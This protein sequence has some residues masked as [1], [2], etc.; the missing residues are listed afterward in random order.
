MSRQRYHI[1]LNLNHSDG[2]MDCMLREDWDRMQQAIQDERRAQYRKEHPEAD[3]ALMHFGE[4]ICGITLCELDIEAYDLEQARR[5]ALF[6]VGEYHN[7]NHAIFIESRSVVEGSKNETGEK[8]L[9]PIQVV[10]G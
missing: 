8:L 3:V 1:R 9:L 4:I 2:V 7:K 5:I 6:L 10:R